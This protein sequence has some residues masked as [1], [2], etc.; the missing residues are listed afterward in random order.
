MIKFKNGLSISTIAISTIFG[1]SGRGMFP[2]YFQPT[3]QKIV[4]LAKEKG[5]TIFSKSSTRERKMENFVIHKPWTWKYIQRLPR[6]SLLNAYGLTNPGIEKCAREIAKSRKNGFNVVPNFYPEFTKGMSQAIKDTLEATEIY[7]ECFRNDR[8]ILELNLSCPNSKEDIPKNIEMAATC[9]E[10]TKKHYPNIAIIAKTSIL[11]PYKFY[12]MLENSGADCI[13]AINT[14]PW[15]IL[16]NNPSPLKN[17]GG[18]G[19]SGGLS[20]NKS[21]NYT[22]YIPNYTSLPVIFA[23]GITDPVSVWI[24]FENDAKAIAVCTW[25][26]R[27][28]QSFIEFLKKPY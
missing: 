7:C 13:H 21:I 6:L 1:H 24:C 19:I 22:S 27:E 14:I 12:K 5:L 2:Y 26:A 11:H 16:F 3:Y 23:C 8:W 28:P 10:K 9:V 20:W 18:G 15:N 4:R 25:I 17:V